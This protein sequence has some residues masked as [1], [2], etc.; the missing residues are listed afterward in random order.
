MSVPG[1]KPRLE[2]VR[3][4]DVVSVSHRG[5]T[6][7]AIVVEVYTDT[8]EV[9]VRPHGG[10]HLPRGICEPKVPWR[11]VRGWRSSRMSLFDAPVKP[12]SAIHV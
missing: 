7:D 1:R 9:R 2:R 6:F 11:A 3:I 5:R 10:Q 8:R 4:A 12:G